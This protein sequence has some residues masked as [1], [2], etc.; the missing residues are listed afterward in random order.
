MDLSDLMRDYYRSTRSNDCIAKDREMEKNLGGTKTIKSL[1]VYAVDRTSQKVLTPSAIIVNCSEG[2]CSKAYNIPFQTLMGYD[3][4]F[5]ISSQQ[6]NPQG[7]ESHKVA[8]LNDIMYK[9]ISE[10]H[11]VRSINNKFNQSIQMLENSYGD[12]N[13]ED[14]F[15]FDFTLVFD[16]NTKSTKENDQTDIVDALFQYH[17]M[18]LVVEM[19]NIVPQIGFYCQDNLFSMVAS[20]IPVFPKFPPYLD[21]GSSFLTELSQFSV[22][23]QAYDVAPLKSK[24]YNLIF[25]NGKLNTSSF[26][27]H[28]VLSTQCSCYHRP[29]NLSTF[30]AGLMRNGCST[31]P[32]CYSHVSIQSLFFVERRVL[33]G[34]PFNSSPPRPVKNQKQQLS[35]SDS[36]ILSPSIIDSIVDICESSNSNSSSTDS[37][38]SSLSDG[39]ATSPDMVDENDQLVMRELQEFVDSL[40]YID[41]DCSGGDDNQNDS[42]EP[43]DDWIDSFFS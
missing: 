31:C 2:R 23:P 25:G 27:P 8:I 41:M 34:T 26:E 37:Y 7:N 13:E 24:D 6:P 35:D 22:A 40:P 12:D 18:E 14:S 30:L 36:S 42:G 10:E 17:Q 20:C 4:Q 11:I 28:T 38:C 21:P 15:F 9:M 16:T 1:I 33:D 19:A 29:F 3:V 43:E 32:F 39:Y 5:A